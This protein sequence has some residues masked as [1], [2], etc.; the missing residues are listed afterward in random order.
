[1]LVVEEFHGT[2]V[3]KQ[4]VEMVERKGTGHPDQICDCIMDSISVALSQAY[5]SEFGT[6]LH[7]NIDKGL[8]AAGRVE[9][10]F[11]GG[12]VLEP[13]ELTIGDRATFTLAG[14]E[15]PVHDIAVAAAKG[16][17]A[18]NL[19]H[20]DPERHVS[21]RLKLAPGSQE[22]TDI[23]AR[24]GEVMGANDTSAAVGYYPLSPTERAVLAL[25]REL[26]G[27]RFK[28]LYP[29]TGE[30]VKVM[31]LRTGDE[32]D[33]TVAMPLL[34][35]R[36]A[37]ERDYFERKH[38]IET[39]MQ[40]FL[41]EACRGFRRTR[42]HYNTLDQ[43]GRALSGVYLSL[44]GTSAEDADSGQVGRGNRVNGLIPIARPIGTEA[45]AGKN[46]M[47]H[48]GKI[49]NVLSHRIARDICKSVDG[50]QGAY[51]M[52]LSRIGDPVDRP[53]MANAQLVME[54]GR[55]VAEVEGEVREVMQR[56]LSGITEFCNALARGVYPV[57]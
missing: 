41:A 34:A 47:S 46:P 57:C 6:I 16:W 14:K 4:R 10:R 43:T 2:Q 28:T 15:I 18:R 36:V 53:Q 56:Q 48:V 24:P 20:V 21:Y 38:A 45:A 25:E 40:H 51:V 7:H 19:R 22:L 29:E 9:K 32:L 31:G 3:T 23:F 42:V 50:V 44:L 37:S 8:L 5:L 30:D 11:G 49:Y 54:P 39:A 13:M 1:M 35:E 26:N 55:S 27:E 52:L 12:E 17:I 33:L